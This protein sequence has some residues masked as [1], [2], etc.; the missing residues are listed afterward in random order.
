MWTL[1]NQTYSSHHGQNAWASLATNN[2]GYRKIGPNAA[3]GV[4]NV[5][6]MLVAARATNKQAFVVT[7]A[8]NL[9][10]AVYL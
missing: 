4:T 3:D 10:T 2:T 9:I 5:F 7:D 6:L 8:Q 1:I